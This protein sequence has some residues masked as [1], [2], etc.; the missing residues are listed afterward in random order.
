[1]NLRE[2]SC[3]L[4]ALRAKVKTGNNIDFGFLH[5]NHDAERKEIRIKAGVGELKDI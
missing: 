2:G 3:T 5:I 4:I 1:M